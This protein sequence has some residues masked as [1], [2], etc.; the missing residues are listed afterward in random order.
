MK[1]SVLARQINHQRIDFSRAL[2]LSISRFLFSSFSRKTAGLAKSICIFRLDGKLGDSITSTGFIE[3]LLLERHQVTLVVSN[4]QGWLFEG[5][6]D[7]EVIELKKGLLPSI[8]FI[9]K[10]WK[11]GFSVVINTTHIMKART[12]ML[13]SLVSGQRKIS[14]ACHSDHVFS[15]HLNFDSLSTPIQKRFELAFQAITGIQIP[16]FY[17]LQI[18]ADEEAIVQG[19]LKRNKIDLKFFA[20]INPFAGARARNLNAESVL[21][22]SRLIWANKPGLKIILV[23]NSGDQKILADWK[24]RPGFSDHIVLPEVTSFWQNASLIKHSLFIVTPDTSIVHAASALEVPQ[25]AIYRPDLG[26]EKNAQIW[27][28]LSSGTAYQVVSDVGYY[29]GELDINFLNESAL[30]LAVGQLVLHSATDQE[31][32]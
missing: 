21:K 8:F 20:I 27:A 3:S 12:V 16:M 24:R 6:K 29:R 28:P 31:Q 10:F 26:F 2:L 18:P 17:R 1:L 11:R 9:S 15:E 19:T 25:I 30:E 22:I 13:V 5:F 14:F 7:L 4:G 32:I 23:G